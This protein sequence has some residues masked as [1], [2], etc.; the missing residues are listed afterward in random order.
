MILRVVSKVGQREVD[1][2]VLDGPRGWEGRSMVYYWG[3]TKNSEG[4][5]FLPE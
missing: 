2:V 5:G 3:E 4:V 1:C